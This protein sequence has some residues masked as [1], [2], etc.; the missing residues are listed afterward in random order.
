MTFSERTKKVF[1]DIWKYIKAAWIELVILAALLVVDLIIKAVVDANMNVGQSITIIPK[2]FHITYTRNYNA[3]FGSAFGLEK[4]LGPTGVR[5]TLLIITG[6][7]IA[8][9]AVFLVRTRGKH[10]TGRLGLALLVSGALGNFVDRL[11]LGYVRDFVEIEYFGLDLPLIGSSFAIFNIADIG[12]TVGVVLF[13]VY[14]I[15]F[16]DWAKKAETEENESKSEYVLL[17]ENTEK[18]SDSASVGGLSDIDSDTEE[19]DRLSE[20]E[21]KANN[22]EALDG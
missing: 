17:D 11:F 4:L 6:I 13:L 15:F 5:V 8:F 14:I 22:S 10:I 3:A 2:F 9:F 1:A 20:N 18:N 12:V 16:S 7:A 19:K 21:Q